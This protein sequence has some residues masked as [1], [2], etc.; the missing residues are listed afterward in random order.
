MAPIAQSKSN[1]SIGRE[2]KESVVGADFEI[3]LPPTRVI[4]GVVRDAATGEALSGVS[5]QSW[6]FAASHIIG[7]RQ[8]RVTTDEQGHFRLVGMPKSAGNEIV[9][10]PGDEQPYFMRVAQ[11]PDD[12]GLGPVT[13]DIP[14]HR[15]IWITGRVTDLVSGAPVPRASLYYLPFLTNEYARAL[16]EFDASGSVEGTIA[17]QNH[18]RTASDGTFRLVGLPGRAI[19]GVLSLEGDYRQA[20]GA[21]AIE[22]IDAKGHFP[23]FRNPINPSRKWP[24]AMKEINP[25][26]GSD[27]A[28]VDFQLDPGGH[29][30]ITILDPSGE[31]L[32]ATKLELLGFR[33]PTAGSTVDVLGLGPE[34]VR[35]ILLHHKERGLGKVVR[36]RAADAEKGMSV[37]LEPCATFRGQLVDKNETPLSGVEIRVAVLPMEDFSEFLPRVAT[38]ADGKFV[39]R[40]ILPG[41]NYAVAAIG[42]QIDIRSVASD[43]AIEPGETVDFGTIDVTGDER[44]EPARTKAVASVATDA[45]KDSK[46][47]SGDVAAEEF[48]GQV[49]DPSGRPAAGCGVVSGVLRSGADG[50]A[51]AELEAGGD[52]RCQ[53][54]VSFRGPRGRS[55]QPG[56]AAQIGL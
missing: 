6:Q 3:A 56:D 11:V 14:L 51:G 34:E 18:Y 22:G 30:Q 47:A 40:G 42:R 4:E 53:G 28:S 33:R 24:T 49:V 10:V 8:I 52:D 23:T 19:V 54:R 15:G 20:V 37:R 29:V 35:T 36:V 1:H 9:A 43:V 38:D 7:E 12:P 5:V 27:S 26:E 25:A 21:D 17:I 46:Q 16:P 32:D 41:V 2:N 48:S 55:W 44:P 50:F 13:V 31:P 39:H 45:P